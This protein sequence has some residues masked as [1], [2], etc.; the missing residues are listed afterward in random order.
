MK[1]NAPAVNWR[2]VSGQTFVTIEA[3]LL[4]GDVGG[5]KTLLG[6]FSPGDRRPSLVTAA[7][8]ATTDHDSLVH[9][10]TRFL[11]TSP[12]SRVEAASFG[13][14]GPVREQRATLTNVPWA[15]AAAEIGERFSIRSVTLLND[16]EALACAVPVL[17][18]EELATLQ[19]G[20]A[21]AGGNA[22]LVAA[23]TGLG[24]ALLHYVDGRYVASPS[25]GGHADYSPRT[26]AE[27]ALMQMLT[28]RYG[29]A[30]WEHVLSGPGLLNIHRF[31]HSNG[32]PACDPSVDPALGPSLISRAALE[33]RCP[34]CI[35]S[36]EMFVTAYGAEAGNLALRCLS[37]AGVYIGGGIAP[38]ILPALRAPGFLDAFRSKAPM[39]ALLDAMPVSVILNEQAGLLGAAVFANRAR[40]A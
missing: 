17:K 18:R 2:T 21:I 15:V 31:M 9:I 4:A 12:P 25:E 3:M 7:S 35:E 39:T 19:E 36:L 13:V 8:F 32:C 22:A 5:T 23:G 29:R 14:A 6:L 27:V 40:L 10:I 11:E 38:K 26:P 20:R 34:Q 30:E 24:E 1:E 33:R 37:T 28:A 16:L